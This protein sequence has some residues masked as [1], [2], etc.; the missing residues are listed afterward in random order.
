MTKIQ[1]N[2]PEKQGFK[3]L[4]KKKEKIN[5]NTLEKL[6]NIKTSLEGRDNEL[7]ENDMHYPTLAGCIQAL[8]SILDGSYDSM[9]EDITVELEMLAY[10]KH[11]MEQIRTYRLLSAHELKICYNYICRV[12]NQRST[13]YNK[14]KEDY[15]DKTGW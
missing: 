10:V 13:I 1:I 9:V 5:V 4:D 3:F 15:L 8:E 6:M 7:I 14:L 2:E 11:C 12:F